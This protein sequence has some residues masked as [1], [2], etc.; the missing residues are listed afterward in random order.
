M[1]TSMSR[2]LNRIERA[3]PKPPPPPYES[4]VPRI[5]Q[6]LAERGIFPEPSESCAET[7]ARAF[8]MTMSELREELQRRARGLN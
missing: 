2:R 8:G 7:T 6:F 4:P 5:M 1:R 3:L